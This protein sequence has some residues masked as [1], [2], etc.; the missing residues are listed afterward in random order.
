MNV[1][2]HSIVKALLVCAIGVVLFPPAESAALAQ[3]GIFPEPQITE[4]ILPGIIYIYGHPQYDSLTWVAGGAQGSALFLMQDPQAGESTW[5]LISGQ[6]MYLRVPGEDPE[7]VTDKQGYAVTS[8]QYGDWG[9]S[10]FQYD[11][12]ELT[13][14]LLLAYEETDILHTPCL[15]GNGWSAIP[16]GGYG[17]TRDEAEDIL[18]DF[19]LEIRIVGEK[20]T[21]Y[22]VSQTPIG[23]VPVASHATIDIELDGSE[24]SSAM[25]STQAKG[26]DPQHAIELQ[27]DSDELIAY[28]RLE[29]GH[30]DAHQLTDC[31]GNGRDVFWKLPSTWADAKVRVT[32]VGMQGRIAIAAWKDTDATAG[33]VTLEGLGCNFGRSPKFDFTAPA[34]GTD[35][36]I[37]VDVRGDIPPFAKLRITRVADSTA[38]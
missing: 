31:G 25:A 26:N 10:D 24:I 18:E 8:E 29:E 21:G 12:R 30:T 33:G 6:S 23:G 32:R 28:I 38:D 17:A 1:R 7:T 19:G 2:K 27:G 20:E 9:S 13:D 5:V 11:Q 14:Y 15:T 37:S 34:K 35:C 4:T 22:V 36:I 16:G 3:G